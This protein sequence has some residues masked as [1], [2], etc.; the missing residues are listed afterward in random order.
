VFFDVFEGFDRGAAFFIYSSIPYN[1]A[2][3][4]AVIG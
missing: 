1:N 3:G 4:Q 2:L